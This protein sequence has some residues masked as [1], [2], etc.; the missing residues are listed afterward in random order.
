MNGPKIYT[1]TG[2]QGTTALLSGARISKASNRLSAYG[3]LDELNSQIG[4]LSA[5]INFS[6]SASSTPSHLLPELQRIQKLA[7]QIQSNLFILGANLAN[8]LLDPRSGKSNSAVKPMELPTDAHSQLEDAIDEMTLGLKPLRNFILPG[9]CSWAAQ[10]HVIRTVSR[11][12]E[13][14]IVSSL[15]DQPKEPW[16]L[17]TISYVNRLSDYYF[18]L[19]RHFNGLTA[20][21]EPVWKPE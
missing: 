7:H 20:H 21:T 14:S 18:I 11:R 5:Q 4:L 15:E 10:A 8:D 19:A 12:A 6:E 9:G 17:S 1:K 3:D 2:D 16:I 13:R